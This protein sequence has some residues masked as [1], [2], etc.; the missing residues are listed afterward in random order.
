M[1]ETEAATKLSAKELNA[2]THFRTRENT[3][4]TPFSVTLDTYLRL[5]LI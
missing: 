1:E 3:P 5:L 2:V 4:I